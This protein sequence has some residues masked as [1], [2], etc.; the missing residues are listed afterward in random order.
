MD[1]RMIAR[2]DGGK[3][4]GVLRLTKEMQRHGARPCWLGYLGAPD[5]DAAVARVEEDGGR[6]WTDADAG[7]RHPRRRAHRH[8]DRSRRRALLPDDTNRARR[9]A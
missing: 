5:V 9:S 3:S 6:R 2:S 8:C 1:Y 4:G 7:P